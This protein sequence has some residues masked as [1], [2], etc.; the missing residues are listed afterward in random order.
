MN[1]FQIFFLGR[2]IIYLT[3]DFTAV[4]SDIS[5]LIHIIL[6]VLRIF[7]IIITLIL[8]SDNSYKFLIFEFYYYANKLNA[9]SLSQIKRDKV[10]LLVTVI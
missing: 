4:F 6:L 7:H 8:L 3:V 10:E 5:L 9:S 2:L 1:L